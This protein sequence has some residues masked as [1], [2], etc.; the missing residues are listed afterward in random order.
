MMNWLNGKQAVITGSFRY[1]PVPRR[2][3]SSWTSEQ[4]KIPKMMML[5]RS[6][7]L[8]T[9]RRCNLVSL[10]PWQKSWVGMI[11]VPL[12][13]SNLLQIIH[14][15]NARKG[16]KIFSNLSFIYHFHKSSSYSSIMLTMVQ[17]PGV[18]RILD[19]FES[20]IKIVW[21]QRPFLSSFRVSSAPQCLRTSL[22]LTLSSSE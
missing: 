18:T 14:T 15:G 1:L 17:S 13:I 4:T 20:S 8:L 22:V 3:V 5:V 11:T 2:F 10:K 6:F 12:S 21:W 7:R 9:V 19:P 16:E